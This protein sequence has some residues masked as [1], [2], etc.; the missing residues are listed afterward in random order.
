MAFNL[1]KL[2]TTGFAISDSSVSLAF[3]WDHATVNHLAVDCDL[4][5]A[6]LVGSTGRMPTERALVFFNNTRSEDGALLHRGD[7]IEGGRSD[8]AEVI[9]LS[10]NAVHHA[11]SFLYVF[12]TIYDAA[13]RGHLLSDLPRSTFR[14]RR[15]NAGA[16]LYRSQVPVE[17]LQAPADSCMLGRFLRS[18]TGWV[19]EPQWSPFVGGLESVVAQYGPA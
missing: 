10:L 16:T 17:P 19:F 5:V 12:L 14:V 2:P 1:R 6:M 8:E 15:G 11:V 4:S 3:E 7:S 18:S 13:A 9:E